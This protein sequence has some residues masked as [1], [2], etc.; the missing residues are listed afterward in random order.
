MDGAEQKVLDGCRPVFE[1]NIPLKV[2]LCTYHKNNDET[3]FAEQ[4]LR[5]GFKISFSKG[6]MINYYDK[7]I[8]APWLRRGLIRAVRG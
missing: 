8:K 3:D 2:A 5:Y 6:Y 4:L 1:S 7:K